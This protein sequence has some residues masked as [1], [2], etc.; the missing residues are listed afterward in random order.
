[1]IQFGENIFY[2]GGTPVKIERLIKMCLN[3]SFA[4]F[5]NVKIFQLNFLF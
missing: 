3:E 4:K 5:L 1:M 2:K